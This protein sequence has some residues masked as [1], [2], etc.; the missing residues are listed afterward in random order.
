MLRWGPSPSLDA[1]DGAG[2]EAPFV[3]GYW[4]WDWADSIAKLE[5]VTKNGNGANVTLPLSVKKNARFLGLNLLSEL[6]TPG[7][8]FISKTQQR[9]FYYPR[10]PVSEWTEAPVVSTGDVALSLDGS[11]HVT[12]EGLV[13]AHAKVAGVSAVNVSDVVVKNCT[14]HGVGGNGIMMSNAVNSAVID[15]LISD[16]GCVGVQLDGGDFA[17]LIPGNNTALRN[18]IFHMARMKRTYQPGLKWG[19]VNNTY[20]YNHISD[21]PHNCILGG[22]NE[23]P[24]ANCLFEFN[25]LDKCSYESSDTGAFYTCGQKANAFVNRGNELRHSLFKNIRNTEGSGVQ[26]ISL[27]AVYL[28]D[29]MSGWHVW[30]NTFWNCMTGTFIGGGEHNNF[31]DNYYQDCDV[32]QHF[33]NRGM[34]WQGGAWNC[35]SPGCT[36]GTNDGASTCACNP[37]AVTT[38]LENGPG[39]AEWQR[40]FGADL[41]DVFTPPCAVA[42]K[43]AVPCHN[44][45]GHNSYCKV[46]KFI[47]AT[48]AQTTSWSSLVE[49]NAEVPCRFSSEPPALDGARTRE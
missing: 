16:V 23:G 40:Q 37:A 29:Q 47:D 32:A 12:V 19:G 13:V 14:V 18:R 49:A 30:N 33:D 45:A 22:G 28:D 4:D 25:T 24:G 27:Q 41:A 7:E 17:R 34:N 26:G 38:Y 2:E 20:S 39:A 48:T 5:S 8:F 35:T 11:R 43:G 9:V 31:H 36:A 10:A 21:G 15:S 46:G 6:D 44:Y 3:H 1:D 42:G